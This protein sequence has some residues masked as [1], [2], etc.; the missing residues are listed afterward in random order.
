MKTLV[1][2]YSFTGNTRAVAEKIAKERDAELVE[3]KEVRKRSKFSAYLS[4]VSAARGQKNS[5]IQ[6]LNVH[7]YDYDTII[8]AMPIWGGYPAPA[9]NNVIE[10]LTPDK[11]IEL[12]MVSKS[13]KSSKSKKKVTQLIYNKVC[14]LSKYTDVTA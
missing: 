7:F 8:I 9:F 13:G 11:N 3:V 1:I 4:G 2:Y 10:L 6:N 5:Y 14:K 12:V